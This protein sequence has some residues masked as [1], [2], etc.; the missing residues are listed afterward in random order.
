MMTDLQGNICKR[1]WLAA[2]ALG[3]FDTNKAEKHP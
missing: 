2:V 1:D 3:G